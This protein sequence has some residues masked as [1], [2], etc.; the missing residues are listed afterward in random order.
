VNTPRLIALLVAGTFLLAACGESGRHADLRKTA[1]NVDLI[2]SG[3]LTYSLL[4]MPQA[5]PAA[6]PFGFRLHGP[7]TFGDNPSG[8]VDYTQIANGSKATVTVEFGPR[9]GYTIAR[10]KRRTLSASQLSTLRQAAA[11]AKA[12]AKTDIGNWLDKPSSCGSDCVQ[13]KLHVANTIVGLVGLTGSKVDLTKDEAA[14]LDDAARSA[15]YVVR[16]TGDH[17]L[18]ELR[19]HIALAFDVPSKLRAALGNLVGARFDFQLGIVD[20][21]T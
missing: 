19:L 17:L 18:R 11:S 7:F 4:V 8:R 9:G 20:P 6:Q 16:W 21:K 14:Q 3:T 13:G 10:G 15:T 5:K 1:A 2:R 12:G